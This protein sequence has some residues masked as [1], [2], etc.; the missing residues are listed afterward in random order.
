VLNEP[1]R[2]TSACAT[3]GS[4]ARA[5]VKYIFVALLAVVSAHEVVPSTRVVTPTVIVCHAAEEQPIYSEIRAVH[6]DRRRQP[7]PPLYMSRIRSGPVATDL[8]QRP[9]PASPFFS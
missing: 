7:L 8:F 6:P 1:R 5:M 9:P 3:L 4:M 2:E